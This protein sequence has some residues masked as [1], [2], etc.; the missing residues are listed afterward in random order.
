MFNWKA[1]LL[2][3]LTKTCAWCIPVTSHTNSRLSF[4]VFFWNGKHSNKIKLVIFQARGRVENIRR[5]RESN[6]RLL[7]NTHVLRTKLQ[8]LFLIQQG[9]LTSLIHGQILRLMRKEILSKELAYQ[10]SKVV[11]RIVVSRMWVNYF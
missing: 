9:Y 4:Y 3:W 11:I 2:C 10:Y 1:T 5:N 6:M 7:L 8:I